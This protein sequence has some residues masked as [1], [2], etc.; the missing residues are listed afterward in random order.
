MNEYEVQTVSGRRFV[1]K[2]TAYRVVDGEL[3]FWLD[4]KGGARP[5]FQAASGQWEYVRETGTNVQ[6]K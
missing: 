4:Q 6:S 3:R 2:A 1:I 5:I